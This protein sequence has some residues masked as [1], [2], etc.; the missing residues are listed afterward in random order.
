M[1]EDYFPVGDDAF[2]QLYQI[3]STNANV[4]IYVNQ[5]FPTF[6]LPSK[7]DRYYISWLEHINIPWL[8]KQAELVYP[9]P[10]L[11]ANETE[12]FDP[13]LLNMFPDNIEF[14]RWNTWGMQI[15]LSR[16]HAGIADKP[17]PAKYKISS[18]AHRYSQYKKFVT[19]FLLEHFDHNDLI[20]S[21]HNWVAKDSDLH[22][23]PAGFKH[24][25]SLNF[26]LL[27]EKIQLNF[28]DTFVNN[29]INNTEWKGGPGD[30]AVVTL[31]NESYHYSKTVINGT[32]VVLPS[33]YLTE[34]TW[35]PLLSAKPFVI[36]GGCYGLHELNTLGIRTDFGWVDE[37]D[38][39]PGDLTRIGKIFNTLLDINT[40]TAEQLYEESLP[41]VTHNLQHIKTG[42]LLD[43]CEQ[44]NAPSR[45]IIRDFV[46]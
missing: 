41:A 20:L 12:N 19:A 36:I 9:K 8:L 28:S 33:P 25:D 13:A 18:L 31:T 14:I 7:Y 37:Y 4:G 35:K 21:W 42:G 43:A 15:D 27:N 46:S 32:E 39:D 11:V 23:H 1:L 29:A 40:R 24:I 10:I 38:T 2:T 22:G 16:Q 30:L 44:I 5:D 3:T 26:E 34:K 17:T 6:D 45:E